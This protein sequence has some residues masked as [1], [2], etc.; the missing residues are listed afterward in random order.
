MRLS[1]SMLMR[2][3]YTFTRI[4]NA[5]YNKLAYILSGRKIS[6]DWRDIKVIHPEAIHIGNN[7]SAGRGL[8]LESVNGHGCLTIGNNVNMSD[9]VHIGAY[10]SVHI[11][12]G[13]L[14]GSRVLISDHS[15]GSSPRHHGFDFTV[16][17]NQRPITSKG[18]VVIG[19]RVWLGDG[20]CV[21][22]GV[23]VGDEAIVGAN[24]IIVCDVPART[25][26]AGVPARQ[27]WP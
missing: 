26:W 27:V 16:P 18:P 8:W 22:S 2:F 5:I 11:G 3:G 17:P 19:L 10:T 9:Y 12:D 13:V 20:V 14:L 21:L 15:H 6:L 25:V 23:N 4:R 24:S 1:L 7:F